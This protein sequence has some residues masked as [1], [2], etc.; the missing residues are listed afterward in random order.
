MPSCEIAFAVRIDQKGRRRL[1]T[2]LSRKPVNFRS[3]NDAVPD[4]HRAPRPGSSSRT[5]LGAPTRHLDW[6]RPSGPGLTDF[7]VPTKPL[8]QLLP[9]RLPGNGPGDR[10]GDRVHDCPPRQIGAD[11]AQNLPRVAGLALYSMTLCLGWSF[12]AAPIRFH[13]PVM[14]TRYCRFPGNSR[15]RSYQISKSW[16]SA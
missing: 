2:L 8:S 11:G 9:Y 16:V 6:L 1:F 12:G 5:G 13:Q 14:N 3:N 10:P 7:R 15:L 4:F